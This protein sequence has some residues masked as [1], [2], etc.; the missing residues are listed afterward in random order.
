MKI[1]QKILNRDRKKADDFAE[2]PDYYHDSLI[3]I[4]SELESFG[5]FVK[6][7]SDKAKDIN[8]DKKYE[9]ININ[10]PDKKTAVII[11]KEL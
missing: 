5:E 2:L 8:S 4:P 11:Y 3:G 9:V 6:R 1:L 10:Y 7:V